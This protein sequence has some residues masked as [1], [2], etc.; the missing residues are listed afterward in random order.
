[1]KYL[2]LF[3][4]VLALLSA[5]PVHSQS[6]YLNRVYDHDSTQ[7][8]GYNVFIEDDGNYFIIGSAFD[9]LK[10]RLRLIAKRI[11]PDGT[12]LFSKTIL[13]SD[14]YNYF[15]GLPGGA[16][17]LPNGDYLVPISR[18]KPHAIL[19]QIRIEAGL[20]RLTSNGDILW[21]KYYTD[22]LSSIDYAWNCN[23]MPDGGFLLVG[24]R[25]FYTGTLMSKKGFII[26]TD[27]NGDI[28]W[29]KVH[30]QCNS[31]V[32]AE[33][34]NGNI[35]VGGRKNELIVYNFQY[36][37]YRFRPWFLVYDILGNIVTDTLYSTKFGGDGLY[38]NGN[39][40]RDLNGGYFTYGSVDSVISL[41]SQYINHPNF[42]AHLNDNF[43]I[44]WIRYFAHNPVKRFLSGI[45]Q[46]ADSSYLV[47][48]INYG[49]D[50]WASKIDKFGYVEFDNDFS[51]D[52]TYDCYLV[53]AAERP[54][55]AIVMTGTARSGAEPNWHGQD[56]WVVVVDSNGCLIPNCSP[57]GASEVNNASNEV[58]IY[59]N[60]TTGSFTFVS[61]GPG[62]L[63]ITSVNGPLVSRIEVG[64]GK[65][66]IQLPA[67]V[68]P[69]IYI[70]SFKAAN[71]ELIVRRLIYQP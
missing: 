3:A 24:E 43:E 45:E 10:G 2:I 20:A 40:S 28:L 57:T 49:L 69:G 6:L 5:V 52:T 62:T 25:D 13:E 44:T 34:D 9:A 56:A 70:A 15:R 27:I 7:D 46:L 16:K 8:W 50:S 54:D 39:I 64:N 26:R 48:G 65:N 35:L 68:V 19:S 30:A 32:T 55:H 36:D 60:P 14:A 51:V 71:G 23:V 47:M 21:V 58:N 66:N 42:L 1:M 38:A 33:Y 17:R 37:Y 63:T 31:F 18:E 53:A 22:T 41:S 29:N 61:S 59:P 4:N 11:A 12:E 67:S